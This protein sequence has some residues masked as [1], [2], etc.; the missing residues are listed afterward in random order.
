MNKKKAISILNDMKVKISNHD[1]KNDLFLGEAME[2][3]LSFLGEE[4]KIFNL[5]RNLT[6]S[7]INN[8]NSDNYNEQITNEIVLAS[9]RKGFCDLIDAAIRNID[10]L[11]IRTAKPNFLYKIEIEKIVYYLGAIITACFI[12]GTLWGK[13]LS[14]TQNIEIKINEKILNDSIKKLN[15]R[16]VFFDSSK[17]KNSYKDTSEVGQ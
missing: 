6:R 4:N 7:I 1:L 16:I 3:L 8:R 9:Y 12:A 13:Y 11:G 10:N 14:D 2:Y 15:T 5:Y 17:Y